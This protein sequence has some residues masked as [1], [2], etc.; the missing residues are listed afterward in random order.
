MKGSLLIG[1]PA[2]FLVGVQARADTMYSANLNSDSEAPGSHGTGHA[3]LDYSS[4]MND[5]TY[6][7]DFQNLGSDAIMS[8]IH[9]GLPG[10]T[11]PILLWFFP[12]SLTPTPT[13]T[14]GHYT[15]TWTPADLTAQSQDPGVTTFTQLIAALNAG[16]VYVNVHSVNYPMGEIRGQLAM[17]P[18]PAT[19]ALIGIPLLLG[20]TALRRKHARRRLGA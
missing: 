1:A 17:T 15:G 9:F 6:T 12:A 16:E 3:L 4:A 13:A 7:L 5:I 11:G 10:V 18:E 8:H 19:F 20:F 2:V 14:S